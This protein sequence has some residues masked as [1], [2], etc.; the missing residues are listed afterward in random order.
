MLSV[1]V[2]S[3]GVST[4][5]EFEIFPLEDPYMDSLYSLLSG[6]I[7]SS[8][9]LWLSMAHVTPE[10]R[11]IYDDEVFE[12]RSFDQM[13]FNQLLNDP[14][15]QLSISKFEYRL[16]NFFHHFCIPMFSFGI[17]M[18]VESVWKTQVP[19]LFMKS[20]LVRSAVFSFAAL[21]LFPLCDLNRV[22]ENDTRRIEFFAQSEPHDSVNFNPFKSLSQNLATLHKDTTNYFLTAINHTNTI[23]SGNVMSNSITKKNASELAVSSVLIFSFLCLQ[24]GSITPLVCFDRSESDIISISKGIR[25]TLT[26][27]APLLQR[28]EFAGLFFLSEE[29]VGTPALHKSTF[30]VIRVLHRDF[31][32]EFA[33]GDEFSTESLT[34]IEAIENCLTILHTLVNRSVQLDYPVPFFRWLLLLNEDF[35]VLLYGQYFFA[36]RVMF[37]YASVSLL[38]RF[39]LY[40][41]DN[42]WL[43]YMRWYKQHNWN[44]YGGWR[45]EWD[46]AFYDISHDKLR[47]FKKV[48]VLSNFDPLSSNREDFVT[49]L[50]DDHEFMKGMH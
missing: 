46:A 45:Y 10:S 40:Q 42:V 25:T 18:E 13:L 1:K 50:E 22:C 23:V 44:L 20:P 39:E 27:C 2:S 9:L 26:K 11:T 38:M 35:R 30:P 5:N 6:S 41:E 37:A 17:N 19:V 15:S 49:S 3:M 32:K 47:K 21:N 36:L 24:P 8:P 12:S 48:G 4:L 28:S 33:S 16:L 29:A 7:V 43:D 31:L 14:S 34:E